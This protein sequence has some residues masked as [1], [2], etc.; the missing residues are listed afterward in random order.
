ML[1]RVLRASNNAVDGPS[2]H[3]VP[4]DLGDAGGSMQLLLEN[5][6]HVA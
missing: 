2:T 4:G 5:E 3:V 1:S 6:V